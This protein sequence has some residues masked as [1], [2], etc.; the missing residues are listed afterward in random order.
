ML[1]APVVSIYV[2]THAFG[3]ESAQDSVRFTDLVDDVATSLHRDGNNGSKQLLAPLRTLAADRDFW[4]HQHGSVAVFG[5]D[6]S[7]EC[8]SLMAPGIETV[9]VDEIP[10]VLPLVPHVVEVTPF[11]LLALSKNAVRL[12]ECDE[13]GAN[14]VDGSRIP[15]S[16]EDAL[17]FEDPQP[18]LQFHST[19]GISIAHGHG[20]GDEVAK[21]RLDRFLHAVDRAIVE[22]EE[23][24]TRPMVLATVDSTASRFRHVS[25]YPT[26]LDRHISGNPDRLS[27]Q[28]LHEHALAIVRDRDF[29]ARQD[30]IEHIRELIGTGN[31][32]THTDDI[33]TSALAGRIATLFLADSDGVFRENGSDP[34]SRACALNRA[35]IDTVRNGGKVA[36]APAPLLD[37]IDAFAVT[38]W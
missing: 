22:R 28:H 25:A 38:R 9:A 27:A 21:Q 31:V 3:R 30:D 20:I 10:F 19:G 2:N 1:R 33:A 8:F 36:L 34:D 24:P 35:V 18:Q 23:A 29:A 12:F 17:R 15:S 26:I 37:G 14:E 11:L 32:D 13:D 16:F 6:Y 4:Q 5:N 7:W